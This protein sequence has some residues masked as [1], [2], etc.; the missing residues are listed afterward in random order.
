MRIITL[1]TTMAAAM[2]LIPASLQGQELEVTPGKLMFSTNPGSSQTQQVFIK[3][4]GASDQSFIF[5]LADWLTDENSEIRYFEPGSTARSCA[6]WVT[7]TPSVVSLQPNESATVNVT[8]LV[9]EDEMSTR[10]AMLFVESAKEQTGPQ[11]IDKD[12]QMGLTVSARIAVPVYQS[13]NG[14]SFYKGTID[15][16]EEIIDDSGSRKFESEVINI[17]DKI[18][19]CKVYYTIVNLNTAEEITS[20]PIEFSLLPESSKK[21]DYSPDNELDSGNY[22]V[23]AILDYGHNDELDGVQLDVEIK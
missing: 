7:V 2:W 6:G 3:N 14:N 8:M 23:T 18:L 9:P 1:L 19:N 5:N 22:S 16:L 15:N 17:G 12:V 13:P 20:E 4:K 11:A 21:V 10:W